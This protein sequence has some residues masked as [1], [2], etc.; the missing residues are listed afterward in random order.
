MPGPGD[1][2][3][4]DFLQQRAPDDPT[5]PTVHKIDSLI[6]ML[7]GCRQSPGAVRETI[8]RMW[9][10]AH[11]EPSAPVLRGDG[12]VKRRWVM[13]IALESAHRGVDPGKVDAWFRRGGQPSPGAIADAVLEA[14]TL[15][16]HAFVEHHCPGRVALDLMRPAVQ[17]YRTRARAKWPALHALARALRCD[18]PR[19]RDDTSGQYAGEDPLRTTLGKMTRDLRES[20][21]P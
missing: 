19:R 15:T 2:L 10:A 20:S 21:E 6:A 12:P 5:F 4:A 18:L 13:L 7:L 11:G 17:H 14:R 9:V 3:P 8:D 1:P 16:A